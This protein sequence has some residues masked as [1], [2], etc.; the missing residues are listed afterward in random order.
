MRLHLSAVNQGAWSGPV[1]N[2]DPTDDLAFSVAEGVNIRKTGDLITL[3]YSEI[4]WLKQTFATRSESVTPFL[5]NYWKGTLEIT[6]S[7]D[8]WVDTVRIESKVTTVEVAATVASFCSK[9]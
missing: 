3:D 6:P 7:S 4:E 5:V 2:V 1:E 9:Q 8:N